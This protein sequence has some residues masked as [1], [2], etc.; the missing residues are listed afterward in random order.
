MDGKKG[1]RDNREEKKVPS[2]RGNGGKDWLPGTDL[3]HVTQKGPSGQTGGNSSYL[4]GVW[5][6]YKS[7]QATT[8]KDTNISSIFQNIFEDMMSALEGV[9]QEKKSLKK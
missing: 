7:I 5:G 3:R 4:C 9:T 6:N 8:K 2:W 1:N